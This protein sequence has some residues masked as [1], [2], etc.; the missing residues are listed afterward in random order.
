MLQ[1]LPLGD[2]L[3]QRI[4]KGSQGVLAPLDGHLLLPT[5]RV[6]E[7]INPVN[8]R[9]TKYPRIGAS[10]DILRGTSWFGDVQLGFRCTFLP[11]ESALD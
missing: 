9:R 7:A 10:R 8:P 11:W 6:A 3:I 5:H 1:M 4:T 2:A